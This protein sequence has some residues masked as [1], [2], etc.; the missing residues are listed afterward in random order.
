M[1]IQEKYKVLF[2]FWVVNNLI[3]SEVIVIIPII[4]FIIPAIMALEILY[5]LILTL[6]IHFDSLL[7]C[8]QSYSSCVYAASDDF[9]DY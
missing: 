1:Q 6:H 7:Y 8:S 4:I 3:S 5:N 2:N 9:D